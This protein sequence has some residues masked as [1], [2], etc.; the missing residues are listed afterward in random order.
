MKPMRLRPQGYSFAQAQGMALAVYSP[1]HEFL[2]NL[3]N[4]QGPGSGLSSIF[5]WS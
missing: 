3:Q 5:S 4:F 1:G 2:Q